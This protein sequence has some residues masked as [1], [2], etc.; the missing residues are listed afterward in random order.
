MEKILNVMCF[1]L[2]AFLAFGMVGFI[3]TMMKTNRNVEG[4]GQSEKYKL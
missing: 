4:C 2:L 1:V 3:K